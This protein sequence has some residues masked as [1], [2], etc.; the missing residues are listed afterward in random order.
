[1]SSHPPHLTAPNFSG[2]AHGFFSR[3][4]GV[5]D[6]FYQSLN[7][8]PGSSDSPARVKE[9]RARCA[10]ALGAST[11]ELVT[12]YQVHSATALIATAP[13]TGTPPHGDAVVTDQPGLA[14]GILT[15]D[16]MPFLLADAQAGVIAAAHAGWRGAL[17]GIL[18][19]TIEKMVS[20]GAVPERIIAALG[21]CLRQPNFE[22]GLDLVQ[23][24]EQQYPD[25][26]E[27][28]APGVNDDKRQFDLAGFGW[29]QL[30]SL[31]ITNVFDTEV[32]TLQEQ[33]D[34][35]S[36]RATKRNGEPDYGRNFSGICLPPQ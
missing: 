14:I 16:C 19:A 18:P 23:A 7:V 10:L 8:G 25:I 34:Y 17:A 26:D 3:V 31:G 13:F 32:C 12:G 30:Q 36:Y 21:P 4:G 33:Q 35:F 15:A 6:G 22:V 9:N 2:L 29:R 27:F 5:S 1:M 20:L 11:P 24:F 28:L